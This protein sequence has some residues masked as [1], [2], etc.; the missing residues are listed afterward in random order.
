M[1][2]NVFFWLGLI[3][4]FLVAV[5]AWKG[6]YAKGDWKQDPR[7][8]AILW[9]FVSSI[10]VIIGDWDGLFS[11]AVKTGFDKLQLVLSYVAGAVIGVVLSLTIVSA[12]VFWKYRLTGWLEYIMYGYGY[13][14]KSELTRRDEI[15]QSLTRLFSEKGRVTTTLGYQARQWPFRRGSLYW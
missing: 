9:I 1:I 2:A 15:N 6:S 5:L 11:E 10:V 3:I 12:G 8:K 4:G 7:F 14:E 13:L